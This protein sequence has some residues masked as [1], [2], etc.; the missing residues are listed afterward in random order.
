[1]GRKTS[2]P[3]EGPPTP[4]STGSSRESRS[5]E[6]VGDADA[7]SGSFGGPGTGSEVVE[8]EGGN[9]RGRGP[10][11]L[12]RRGHFKSRLG[13]LNCKRRRVK[14]NELR[15]ECGPCRRLGLACEYSSATTMAASM[16]EPK[17]TISMLALEDL[18]FYHQF[19]TVAYP[20]LPLRASEVWSQC[21]AMSHQVTSLLPHCMS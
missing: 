21:A 8:G 3:A 11:V 1:M 12:R 16:G 9:G 13:C 7:N 5:S 15:P 14:C 10:V 20:T 4:S 17:P 2:A 19:L 6:R 18:K